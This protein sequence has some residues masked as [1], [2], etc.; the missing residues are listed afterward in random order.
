MITNILLKMS[1]RKS[2]IVVRNDSAKVAA[3]I[4][5][6]ISVPVRQV[7]REELNVDWEKCFICQT[8][9]REALQSSSEARLSDPAKAYIDLG[10][11]IL[12]FKSLNLLPAPLNLDELS[13]VPALGTWLLNHKAKFHKTCKLKFG[14]K[15]LEKA[16]IRHEK[17]E[18]YE[19]Q[20][21]SKG[22]SA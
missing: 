14:N 11:C 5:T 10:E 4:S 16:I 20:S 1:K 3:Q 17:Q 15:K 9:T 22:K 6:T 2:V 13:G 7:N 19:E 21:S 8:E 12:K 18:K